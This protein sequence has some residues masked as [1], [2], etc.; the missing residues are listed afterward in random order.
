MGFVMNYVLPILIFA[1]IGAVAGAL[2]VLGSKLLHV[3]MDETVAR[4]T[5]ELPGGN[6]GACGYSGCEGYANAVAK[7]DAPTNRCKPGGDEAAAALA[8]IMGTKA[9]MAE[10]EVAYVRCNGCNGAT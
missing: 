10:K 2:L 4:L 1:V 9:I 7:G 8:Y 6:C 3:E 5:E